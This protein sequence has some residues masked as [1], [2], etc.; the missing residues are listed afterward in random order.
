[1][2][3]TALESS[4]ESGQPIELYRFAQGTDVYLWTSAPDQIEYNGETYNPIPVKRE[5][6]EVNPD[7]RTEALLM[8]VPASLPL[9]RKYINSVPG[10]RATLTIRRFHR[11]DGDTEVIQLFKGTVRTIGFHQNGLEAQIAVMPISGELSN[12]VPR[13][14]YSSVCNH[15]L[16]DAACSVNQSDFRHADTV[17]AVNGN[18]LT[19]DGLAA[20]GDG[21]ANGG[22]IAVNGDFRLIVEQ[23]GSDIRLAIPFPT[24]LL[25][26]DVE[27]FAGCD[28]SAQTCNDK[29]ANIINNGGYPFVPLRNIFSTGLK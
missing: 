6:V 7:R 25:G 26:V 8:T 3:Y 24:S 19:V 11:T 10:Q 2:T 13:F 29:F 20:E 22:F 1:M 23:T 5:R 28:H 15:V 27:V 21:W 17:T 16:Y 9:V 14:V 12:A 18:I 4:T